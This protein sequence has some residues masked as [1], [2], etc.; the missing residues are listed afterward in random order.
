[1]EAIMWE[2]GSAN[3]FPFHSNTASHDRLYSIQCST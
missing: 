1:M 3:L 2:F